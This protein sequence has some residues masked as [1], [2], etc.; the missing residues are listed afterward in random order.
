MIES[1]YDKDC[2]KQRLRQPSAPVDSST[3][4]PFKFDDDFGE[5]E[6][7]GAVR[8]FAQWQSKEIE[9]YID[10]LL[11]KHRGYGI[12]IAENRQGL[13]ALD[14]LTADVADFKLQFPNVHAKLVAMLTNE[15]ALARKKV[16]KGELEVP[17]APQLPPTAEG[18]AGE[19]QLGELK[20][21]SPSA[22]RQKQNAELAR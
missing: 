8:T 12:A 4:K 22:A 11:K 14:I 18:A 17:R 5:T 10:L 6:L 13:T 15:V 16:E 2:Y 3:G 9:S 1:K 20:P 19:S 7:H 21:N